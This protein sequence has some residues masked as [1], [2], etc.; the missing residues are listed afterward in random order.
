MKILSLILMLK[1]KHAVTICNGVYYLL[2]YIS[3]SKCRKRPI[4]NIGNGVRQ[5]I[6]RSHG[7]EFFIFQICPAQKCN[8]IIKHFMY[9]FA[10]EYWQYMPVCVYLRAAILQCHHT[11]HIFLDIIL[12]FRD[13]YPFE[14]TSMPNSLMSQ[15]LC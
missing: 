10:W 4:I 12:F 13:E 5:N 14:V 15:T 11:S 1:C 9:V 7:D 3:T 8:K 6:S 2:R